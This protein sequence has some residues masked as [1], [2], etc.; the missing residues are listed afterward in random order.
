MLGRCVDCSNFQRTTPEEGECRCNPP[1]IFLVPM[2]TL[3]GQGIGFASQFPKVTPQAW[4]G[5]FEDSGMAHDDIDAP[6]GVI[7]DSRD[8]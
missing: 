1:M 2:Q 7:V 4:C 5:A 6:A 8:G 3:Q